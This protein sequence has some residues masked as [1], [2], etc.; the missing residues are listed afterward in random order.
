MGNLSKGAKAGLALGLLIVIGL[1]VGLGLGLTLGGSSS[2]S[3]GGSGGQGEAKFG[4]L[5]VTDK[6]T[7]SE[8]PKIQPG[9][10]MELKYSIQ[11][12]NIHDLRVDWLFSTDNGANYSVI[13]SNKEG[14]TF[15]YELPRDTFTS[16]AFF[17]VRDHNST[18]DYVSSPV[19]A[20]A[21]T[22]LLKKGPGVTSANSIIYVDGNA[23][24]TFETDASLPQL[25][26]L[27]DFEVDYDTDKT[28]P[29]PVAFPLSG[30]DLANSTISYAP[31][32]TVANVFTRLKTTSLVQSGFPEELESVSRYPIDV[33]P[34]PSCGGTSPGPFS[35]CEVYMVGSNGQG[36]NFESKEAV[37]LKVGY[38]GTFGDTTITFSYAVGSASPV[39]LPTTSGPTQEGDDTVAY[40]ATL[41]DL[42][43]TEL[44]ILATA[45]AL[46]EV[47]KS[48][49]TV[50]PYLFFTPPAQLLVYKA[51]SPGGNEVTT[52]VEF[53]PGDTG[54]QTS[55]EVGIANPDGS[56]EKFFPVVSSLKG[57]T[58]VT[59]KWLLTQEQV[60]FG[61]AETKLLKL[62]F[63]FTGTAGS[64]SVFSADTVPL[65][66]SV[67]VPAYAPINN[68]AN[69]SQS[70]NFEVQQGDPLFVLL[71]W[72]T[73]N[74]KAQF[75]PIENTVAGGNT[76]CQFTG[77][78]DPPRDYPCWSQLQSTVAWE[79]RPGP[80]DG[81]MGNVLTFNPTRFSASIVPGQ[82]DTFNFLSPNGC[83]E[84]IPF[85]GAENLWLVSNAACSTGAIEGNW[86][87]Q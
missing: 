57:T 64:A 19:L 28:F 75:F 20:V 35:F 24:L 65:K 87:L 50:S 23:R 70:A 11:S 15:D 3:G 52:K 43:T 58:T 46:N 10:T 41:P 33:I 17:R 45:G 22:F 77:I 82:L 63:R 68:K 29:A 1:A 53:A 49:Y 5:S 62:G 54:F 74:T 81:N 60:D 86:D 30:F 13:S 80:F 67:W 38:E 73:P 7:R 40:G 83:A 31:V 85:P 48:A 69:P 72:A 39:P 56:G 21:P 71:E 2:S 79:I 76:I 84:I 78:E 12:S 59:L 34:K 44:K 6:I 18:G 9:D 27:T 14:N 51:G 61:T 8:P 55:F 36:K 66:K 37:S 16:K 47:S 32:R 42:D 25:S 26:S 4:L